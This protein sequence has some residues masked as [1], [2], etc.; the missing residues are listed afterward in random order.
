MDRG[1][2][3]ESGERQRNKAQRDKN[4]L[5]TNSRR[6]ATLRR[7]TRQRRAPTVN[8]IVLPF[9]HGDSVCMRPLTCFSGGHGNRS[10]LRL[11]ACWDFGPGFGPAS[12]KHY[13]PRLF[14]KS[15]SICVPRLQK[16][17]SFVNG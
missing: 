5:E 14:K 8:H 17:N 2:G 1:H 12:P 3:R 6:D 7:P 11:F 4:R 15:S 9:F 13:P 10:S 16:S